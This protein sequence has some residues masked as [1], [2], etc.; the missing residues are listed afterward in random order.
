[1]NEVP[2]CGPLSWMRM[3]ALHHRTPAECMHVGQHVFRSTGWVPVATAVAAASTRGLA[4][5]A[6]SGK[7]KGMAGHTQ[8]VR[9]RG[10]VRGQNYVRL[11]CTRGGVGFM[12][13]GLGCMV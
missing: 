9:I 1:M 8:Q 11:H 5:A 13:Q 2:L 10:G 12:V 4:P 3:Q 7:G 6:S